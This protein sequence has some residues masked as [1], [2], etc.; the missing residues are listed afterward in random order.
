[1]AN[2][3]FTRRDDTFSLVSDI[4]ENFVS[5]NLNDCSFDEVSVVEILDCSFN[6]GEEISRA[7]YVVNCDTQGAP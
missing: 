4:D 7:S 1:M 2:R 5:I 6:G 3:K